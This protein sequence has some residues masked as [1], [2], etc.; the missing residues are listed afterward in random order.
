[1]SADEFDVIRTWFAPLAKDAA[2]RGLKDDAAVLESSGRLV[3][4]TDA[5]V[6]G[7]HFLPQDPIATVAMKAVRVNVSDLIA[8]GARP[9]YALLTLIW[10]DTRPAEDLRYFG[11]AIAGEFETFGISMLGGDTTATKG[12]LTVSVTLFGEPLGP[13][14]PARAD[15]LAGDDVWLA[16]GDIGSAWMG[17][18]LRTGAMGMAELRRERDEAAARAESEAL[19]AEMPDF[20]RLPGEEFDAEAAWLQSLYLAPMLHTECAG[21]VAAFA[22]AS[23]DVSDGLV[24]DARKLAAASNVALRIE[25]NA[26]PFAP[27]A[28]RWAFSGGDVRKLISGGDD[29]VVLFTAAPTDRAAIAALDADGSLRLSRIGVAEAGEGVRMVDRQGA[30]LPLDEGGHAHKLGR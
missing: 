11:D 12:P 19:A 29:Y 26:I 5:I 6:E 24:A 23:M 10:P 15:A 7:V 28:L 20:L 13:R 3:I 1:M 9:R 30:A 16:G 25:A 4:T 17:L 21:L 22:R 2:A 18:Q 27:P 14:T 8:K